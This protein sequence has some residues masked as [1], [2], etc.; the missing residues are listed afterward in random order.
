MR[1]NSLSRPLFSD[2]NI[3]LDLQTPICWPLVPPKFISKV[4]SLGNCKGGCLSHLSF[5]SEEGMAGCAITFGA[6]Y[7]KDAVVCRIRRAVG[8]AGGNDK[9][10]LQLSILGL[11][12]AQP[13]NGQIKKALERLLF[14]DSQPS[15]TDCHLYSCQLLLESLCGRQDCLDCICCDLLTRVGC[16]RAGAK[17]F[18]LKLD[19]LHEWVNLTRARILQQF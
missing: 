10:H 14:P 15:K 8:D 16:Y 19:A 18:H 9:L 2:I 17:V 12:W 3:C 6:K 7:G 13:V 11:L 1:R 5:V 4:E